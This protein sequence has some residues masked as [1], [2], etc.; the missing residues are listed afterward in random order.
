ME[1]GILK[2]KVRTT[3][4]I[5]TLIDARRSE[6]SEDRRLRIQFPKGVTRAY[7]LRDLLYDGLV[8]AGESV[9]AYIGDGRG[10]ALT[11]RLECIYVDLI[12]DHATHDGR[13]LNA[14]LLHL[15]ALGSES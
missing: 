15:V 3:A 13:S 14:S 12:Q 1:N 7:A 9:Q 4:Y 10:A 6:L 5:D 11:L 2:I 8:A